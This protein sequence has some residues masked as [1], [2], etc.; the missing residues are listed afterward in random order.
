MVSENSIPALNVFETFPI[1][2]R[3]ITAILFY[4]VSG[5][6]RNHYLCVRYDNEITDYRISTV[7]S[8]L[9][10]TGSDRRQGVLGVTLSQRVLPVEEYQ[11]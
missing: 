7:L 11:G 10:V 8:V 5:T 4:V 2:K 1:M 9:A 3:L 6:D